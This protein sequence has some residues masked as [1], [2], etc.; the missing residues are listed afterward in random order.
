[1]LISLPWVEEGV[2]MKTLLT[3]VSCCF[4]I[5]A[6][7]W[8]S[9]AAERG[10]LEPDWNDPSVARARINP[11]T[12]ALRSQAARSSDR[13]GEAPL[14]LPRWGFGKTLDNPNAEERLVSRT[15]APA[16][17]VPGWPKCAAKT[18]KTEHIRDQSGIWY[19]D[20]YDFGCLVI[21]V[22]GDRAFNPD[23]KF[24]A[25]L[26]AADDCSAAARAAPRADNGEGDARDRFELLISLNRLPYTIV[27]RCSQ[28]AEAFCRNRA[29]QCSLV[30][31]L[32]F[33]EG[34]PR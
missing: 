12:G 22:S 10:L 19:T 28:G 13:A 2:A 31:R 23:L 33:L 30:G 26:A 18:P 27:G 8:H 3:I 17:P 5:S 21:S 4:V 1:M 32:L 9:F 24:P 20:H 11:Q 16:G 34:S 15:A 14:S 6:V 25:G 7:H 29:A